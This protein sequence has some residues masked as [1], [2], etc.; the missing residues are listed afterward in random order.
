MECYPERHQKIHMHVMSIDA[1]ALVGI[2]FTPGLLEEEVKQ[3]INW[4]ESTGRK[5]E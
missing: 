1:R 2:L 3:I 5:T 4:R